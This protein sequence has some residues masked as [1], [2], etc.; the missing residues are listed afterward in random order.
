MEKK[1]NKFY[2]SAVG[3]DIYELFGTMEKLK[4]IA[5]NFEGRYKLD[6][7]IKEAVPQWEAEETRVSMSNELW[8]LRDYVYEAYEMLDK[9]V[10]V[11]IVKCAK[12]GAV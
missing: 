6:E 3:E 9:L 11:P 1:E 7:E 5:T 8:I 2:S 4:H 12:G 10:D